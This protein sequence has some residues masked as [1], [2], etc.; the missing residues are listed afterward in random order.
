MKTDK[1]ITALGLLDEVLRDDFELYN[2]EEGYK[3][4]L[5]SLHPEMLAL[6]ITMFH[7]DD[8]MIIDE[9][10]ILCEDMH[11]SEFINYFE[12]EVY[13]DLKKISPERAW[14][15]FYLTGKAELVFDARP[16]V[17]LN[18]SDE[19]AVQSLNEARNY[20]KALI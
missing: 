20:I 16:P 19:S 7:I 15:E 6:C 13:G 12:L 3:M 8:K 17:T 18:Y 9:A 5:V 4:T 1:E 11:V 2:H 14:S 10:M